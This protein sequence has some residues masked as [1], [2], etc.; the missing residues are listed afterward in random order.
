MLPGTAPP[1][2]V[3]WMNP[4]ENARTSPS[5]K[6]GLKTYMSLRWVTIP[7]VWYGSLVIS[8][9]PGFQSYLGS[10]PAASGT[11]IAVL[12]PEDPGYAS[13]SPPVVMS[14]VPKSSVSLTKVVYAERR[15]DDAMSSTI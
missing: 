3:Q 8:T 13:N 12:A 4:H 11:P 2:S 14:P 7:S 15:V 9:S 6:I 10:T 1:T 5:A